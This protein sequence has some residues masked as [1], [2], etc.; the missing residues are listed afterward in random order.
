[1]KKQQAKQTT[2]ESSEESTK[3]STSSLLSSSLPFS[4]VPSAPEGRAAPS[5]STS[6][7]HQGKKESREAL[8]KILD[9]LLAKL[10]PK[11]SRAKRLEFLKVLATEVQADGYALAE[12]SS[13]FKSAVVAKLVPPVQP[14]SMSIEEFKSW[15]SDVQ[16]D[17]EAAFSGAQA[18]APSVT[19]IPSAASA[20]ITA[21]KMDVNA[22]LDTVETI[23]ENPLCDYGPLHNY[24][25]RFGAEKLEL[26]RA[27]V[28]SAQIKYALKHASAR[29]HSVWDYLSADEHAK[30]HWLRP[31]RDLQ[32]I[33]ETFKAGTWRSPVTVA[34]TT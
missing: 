5:S 28:E 30:Y 6:S 13:S 23:L 31:G 9:R 19:S 29:L 34:P 20:R 2:N 14:K 24:K 11:Q 27:K 4:A 33:V 17:V 3:E 22:T 12:I 1:M 16:D 32:E 25:T 10:K 18:Q 8:E 7:F 21:N 26:H 15:R